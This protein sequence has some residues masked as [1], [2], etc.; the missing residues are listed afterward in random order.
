MLAFLGWIAQAAPAAADSLRAALHF[1]VADSARVATAIGSFIDASFNGLDPTS[2]ALLVGVA[3]SLA[4]A[5]WENQLLPWLS[6]KI[7]P[8]AGLQTFWSSNK[9]WLN[10]ALPAL[11]GWLVG[12][13]S[14]VSALF[15]AGGN[16]V[17]LA[18]LSLLSAGTTRAGQK[19]ASA[20]AAVLIL[21]ATLSC[22]SPRQAIADSAPAPA[23]S[24]LSHFHPTL[25]ILAAEKALP[26]QRL[27]ATVTPW[28]IIQP[29]VNFNDRLVLR[30]RIERS[31]G[32][33]TQ[34]SGELAIGAVIF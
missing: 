22:A 28:A 19:R 16:G 32:A 31:L 2:R 12:G 25:S 30:A 14:P 7:G 4:H 1:T 13:H 17:R 5:A 34:W 15:G 11:L 33:V 24:L 23:L 10:V 20:A 26:N 29:G 27:N 21:V 3:V 8:I 6:K 9:D 18:V